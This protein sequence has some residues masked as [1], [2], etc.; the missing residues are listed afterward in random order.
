M[1]SPFYLLIILPVSFLQ[2]PGTEFTQRLALIPIVNVTM[3][4]REAI[5]GVFHWRLIGT[6]VAVEVVCVTVAVRI[7]TT[8]LSQEDVVT[9][10]YSGSFGKFFKER[11]LRRA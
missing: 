1:V 7:A 10:S 9:G 6:T 2:S 8:I 11:L 4:F 5:G 3:M